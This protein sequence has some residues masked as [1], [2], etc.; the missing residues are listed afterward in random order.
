MSH[1]C[2]NCDAPCGAQK[3]LCWDCWW[4]LSTPARTALKRKDGKAFKRLQQL[5]EAIEN[6]IPLTQIRI[7]P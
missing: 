1:K 4:S 3:Y 7:T 6:D 5:H 2:P